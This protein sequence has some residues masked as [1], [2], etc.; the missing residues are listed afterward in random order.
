[1]KH[2]LL[3]IFSL[4]SGLLMAQAP[5][6]IPFQ[7]AAKSPDGYVFISQNLS[8]NFK[9]RSNSATGNIVFEE[10]HNL[11]SST[12]GLF[13]TN[14]GQGNLVSGSL[15]PLAN[16]DKD[17][18][19]EV[20]MTIGAVTYPL[21]VKKLNP[22]PHAKYANGERFRISESGDT[23]FKGKNTGIVIPGISGANN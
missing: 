9:L 21:G 19:L 17:F 7:A 13:S 16:S 20:N 15:N 11:L 1:M 6:S 18:F 2:T 10:N 22:V 4:C 23:L 12:L 3:I 14:I 8:V 5:T